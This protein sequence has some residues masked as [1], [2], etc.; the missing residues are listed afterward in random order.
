MLHVV[1]H[2]HRRQLFLQY[3]PSQAHSSKRVR[4][5]ILNA[6]Y[7]F[8]R[9][10]GPWPYVLISHCA[11][12][13]LIILL[14]ACSSACWG[15][16]LAIALLTYLNPI[17]FS[18]NI[19]MVL[20][21]VI[22]VRLLGK[23]CG[24][25]WDDLCFWR[26]N[27]IQVDTVLKMHGYIRVRQM[28]YIIQSKLKSAFQFLR[29]FTIN[30]INQISH[31]NQLVTLIKWFYSFV[32]G[33]LEQPEHNVMAIHELNMQISI[34]KDISNFNRSV[35][36]N[37]AFIYQKPLKFRGTLANSGESDETDLEKEIPHCFWKY[38]L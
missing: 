29:I 33:V 9:F 27:L 5:H 6:E 19:C 13:R 2:K 24:L 32:T 4:L 1:V 15:C 28:V 18:K 10:P 20:F 23:D 38:C 22:G 26:N 7:I 3:G 25:L 16:S 37:W 35:L 11:A 36:H 12:I 31:T 17:S 8:L 21:I 14:P 34:S 30:I